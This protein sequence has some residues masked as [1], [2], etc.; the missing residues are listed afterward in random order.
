MTGV[1]AEV[2]QAGGKVADA[3]EPQPLEKIIASLVTLAQVFSAPVP[4]EDGL[5][6]YADAL[7]KTPALALRLGIRDLIT[8]HM[9]P[10]LPFPAEVLEAARPYH[11]ILDH[12]QTKISKAHRQLCAFDAANMQITFDPPASMQYDHNLNNQEIHD[13]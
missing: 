12:Y 8:K 4:E 1:L 13:G 10:R 6:L 11:Q 2:E 5:L 9:W 7:S 3:L